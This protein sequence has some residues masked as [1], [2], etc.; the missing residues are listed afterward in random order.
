MDFL[1]R[2]G[3]TARAGQP[4]VVTSFYTKANR[5]LVAAIRQA[6]KHG[7]PVVIHRNLQFFAA[8]LNQNLQFFG[9]F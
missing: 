5:D 2:V 3:R 7:Q 4:G 1:H 9:L 6:E 8:F